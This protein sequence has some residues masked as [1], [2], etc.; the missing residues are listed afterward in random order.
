MSTEPTIPPTPPATVFIPFHLKGR[1]QRD[2]RIG[3]E[4]VDEAVLSATAEGLFVTGRKTNPVRGLLWYSFR[5]AWALLSLG[6]FV[7]VVLTC[8][9]VTWRACATNSTANGGC[10]G[11]WLWMGPLITLPCLLI[12]GW[13]ARSVV[14]SF[15][16]PRVVD[17]ISWDKV[18]TI[19][20]DGK[21]IDLA[22]TGSF[23]SF[24]ARLA[25]KGRRGVA[26]SLETIRK[27]RLPGDRGGETG[28]LIRPLWIDRG[29]ALVVATGVCVGA[30]RMEPW[31]TRELVA[32]G[33]P[34][35]A[36]PPAMTTRALDAR[37]ERVCV[38]ASETGAGVRALRDGKDLA[39][40]V[41]GQPEGPL[42]LLRMKGG[43]A[44][45]A[46]ID[47]IKAVSGRQAA[48]FE[49][50]DE[51][52]MAVLL[53]PGTAAT[54]LL[55]A[56][57]I[58]DLAAASCAGLVVD[59]ALALPAGVGSLEARRDGDDLVIEAKD[60]ASPGR[61]L[62]VR[63]RSGTR[64][65]LFRWCEVATAGDDIHTVV[66]GTAP[67]RFPAFFE[68]GDAG[69]LAY[70]VPT[71]RFESARRLAVGGSV[72]RCLQ[73]ESLVGAGVATLR[74]E[75]A[76]D[77]Q[78]ALLRWRTGA[79]ARAMAMFPEGADA[80]A[81]MQGIAGRY[82]EIR[83]AVE[84]DATQSNAFDEAFFD[85][86]DWTAVFDTL[87]FG[88][89]LSAM[90]LLRHEVARAGGMEAGTYALL[91]VGEAFLER[92]P[93]ELQRY[94][95]RFTV[96]ERWLAAPTTLGLQGE[97]AESWTL[98][99]RFILADLGRHL[100][101]DI[102]QGRL[103]LIGT[104]MS[105]RLIYD[106]SEHRVRIDVQPSTARKA[107]LAWVTGDFD[108][109]LDRALKKVAQ[110]LGQSER[111]G[112]VRYSLRDSVSAGPAVR[113][114]KL[115]Q[116]GD[117]IGWV[118]Q[119]DG[120]SVRTRWTL[121]SDIPD[122]ALLA[123]SAAYSE[124]EGHI[125]GVSIVQGRV[126]NWLWKPDMGG[127]IV[128]GHDGSVEFLDMRRG[129]ELGGRFLRPGSSLVDFSALMRTIQDDGGSAFQT[130][131]LAGDGELRL[132]PDRS[133]QEIRERRLLVIARYKG[134]P[135]WCVVDLP[136]P[137]LRQGYTLYQ[138]AQVA[139]GAL[140]TPEPE[141]PGLE[142]L[143][144]ANLDTGAKDFLV[145]RDGQGRVVR[146]TRPFGVVPSNLLLIEPG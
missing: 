2:W 145:A 45:F 126:K 142:V 116:D 19:A 137:E 55:A 71:D 115:I 113:M 139:M 109:L 132:N 53:A 66:A 95:S 107:L 81:M 68:S 140:T 67:Q 30:V 48:F 93:A 51:A 108:Y 3:T 94:R 62:V 88:S 96:G 22:A 50:G 33:T 119:Y 35:A 77:S 146:E 127:L 111:F 69:A 106:L 41:S 138:A 14:R 9:G 114:S 83:A 8:I 20:T 105:W 118:A 61:F 6:A 37:Q 79:R 59:V 87:N 70:F 5:V 141:G 58:E 98:V 110:V 16:E 122:D 31:L 65:E 74:S 24:R 78:H 136:Q 43:D 121:G 124:V 89:D 46:V 82:A 49:A 40:E 97:A 11:V 39:W 99:G 123:M 133:S 64:G 112:D 27:G 104:V 47:E 75:V 15:V 73:P 17:R 134:N 29:V 13:V 12:A 102:N 63:R 4:L 52:G 32:V 117:E 92:F 56:G 135:I 143:A 85:A 44:R 128:V 21:G 1:W 18:S 42:A 34:E 125:A 144:V 76:A 91:R 54:S 103:G 100:E 131:L 130:F 7:S 129:G 36:V 38:G 60:L 25:P 72:Q 84:P 57:R 90:D 10:S 101:D 28:R 80:N 26:P 23:G 86:V 120:R